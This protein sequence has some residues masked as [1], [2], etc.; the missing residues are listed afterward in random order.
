TPID[1]VKLTIVKARRLVAILLSLGY[2]TAVHCRV[3][4]AFSIPLRAAIKEHESDCHHEQDEP[5]GHD[6]KPC[7]MTF[8]GDEALLPTSAP[9]LAP[10]TL[11]SLVP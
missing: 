3:S 8:G 9:V 2:L 10:L 5:K 4:C 1:R 6:S 11:L 7:C